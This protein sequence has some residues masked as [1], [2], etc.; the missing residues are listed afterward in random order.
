LVLKDYPLKKLFLFIFCIT[1]PLSIFAQESTVDKMELQ[2]FEGTWYIHLT[3]FPQWLKEKNQNPTLNYSIGK[4]NDKK[5]LN[6][7][8]KYE[9]NGKQKTISGFDFPLDSTNTQFNWK[10]KGILSLVGSKWWVVAYNSE[11]QWMITQFEN[12][13]FSPAGVDVIS[14]SKTLSES[15]L[16]EIQ[17]VLDTLNLAQKKPLESIR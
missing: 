4:R 9:R 3:N 11:K 12:T 15:E 14:K 6:D 10:G 16:K 7:L 17:Q 2:D 1:I 13:L 8:V 5:G